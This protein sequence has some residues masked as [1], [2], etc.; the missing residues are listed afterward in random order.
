MP[1]DRY[2]V[3]FY[4]HEPGLVVEVDGE[5]HDH[6]LRQDKLRSEMLETYDLVILRFRNEQVF[7]ELQTVLEELSETLCDLYLNKLKKPLPLSHWERGQG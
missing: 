1:I 6:Q 5:I 2:V 7:A 3:D 4:A